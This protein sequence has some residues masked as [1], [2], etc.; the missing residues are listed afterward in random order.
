VGA[1][2]K[3][4]FPAAI[5]ATSP[6]VPYAPGI[7]VYRSPIHGYGLRAVNGFQPGQVIADVEGVLYK[8]EELGDDRYCLWVEDG[9]Y[10]DMVD[11]TRWI[12]H[13]CDPNSEIEAELDGKGGAWARVVALREIQPGE[14]I[15][16]H[17]GFPLDLAEPCTCGDKSCSGWIVDPDSLPELLARIACEQPRGATSSVRPDAQSPNTLR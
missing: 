16:Y 17:Y 2:S 11:Q 14:E 12:N 5:R 3:L 6:A 1:P 9:F 15:T 10:Y 7:R 8:E 13:A 4:G